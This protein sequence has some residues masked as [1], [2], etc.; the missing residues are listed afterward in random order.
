MTSFKQYFKLFNE[1][2]LAITD[3]PGANDIVLGQIDKSDFKIINAIKSNLLSD[4]TEELLK[5]VLEHKQYPMTVFDTIFNIFKKY[6]YRPEDI[7]VLNA[8]LKN[9]TYKTSKGEDSISNI[10]G[11]YST[12]FGI[13]P[14]L[15]KEL[16]NAEPKAQSGTT[17]GKGEMVLGLFTDLKGARGAGDLETSSGKPI[18]V[19]VSRGRFKGQYKTKSPSQCKDEIDEIIQKYL[20]EATFK[21]VTKFI[22]N[23]QKIKNTGGISNT[24]LDTIAPLVNIMPDSDKIEIIKAFTYESKTKISRQF[25]GPFNEALNNGGN[26]SKAFLLSLHLNSYRQIEN[27]DELII[28]KDKTGSHYDSFIRFDN[29]SLSSFNNIYNTLKQYNLGTI[30]G[31]RDTPREAALGIVIK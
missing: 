2:A 30:A 26:Y 28:F 11:Y 27:F 14:K 17:I 18:E 4:N 12:K 6:F 9:N 22:D 25:L 19:K 8:I 16:A 20:N 15:F 3:K 5:K 29:N 24:Y 13:N 23:Y 1:A 7:E 21:D 31:W 10:A